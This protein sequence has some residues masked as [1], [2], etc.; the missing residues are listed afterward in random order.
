MN[1]KKFEKL[2]VKLNGQVIKGCLIKND[3][4]YFPDTLKP[5][6][7]IVKKQYLFGLIKTE[8]TVRIPGCFYLQIKIKYLD[9]EGPIYS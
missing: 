7:E 8:K 5:K 2:E 9:M 1:D 6:V 4:I 3:K